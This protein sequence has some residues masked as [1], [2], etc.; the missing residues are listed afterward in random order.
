MVLANS[1]S[2]N[3]VSSIRPEIV[4]SEDLIAG[5]RLNGTM[6]NIRRFFCLF[7]TF[8]LLLTCLMW[9]ICIMVS[10]SI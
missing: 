6:S 5:Q 3:T 10:F 8:D 1:Q 4:I 2:I 7:I 9:I